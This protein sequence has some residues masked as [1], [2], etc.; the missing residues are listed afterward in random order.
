[1]TSFPTA[2]ELNPVYFTAQELEGKS[3]TAIEVLQSDCIT[4]IA[5]MLTIVKGVGK[6]RSTGFQG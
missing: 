1:M 5:V 6:Y 4:Y 3:L 2:I